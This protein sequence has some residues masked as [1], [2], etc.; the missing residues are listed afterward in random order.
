MATARVTGL[1]IYP[2]KSMRGIAL[3]H[4]SLTPLGLEHDR[5]FMVI[6]EEGR[7]VTQRDVP[8]LALIHTRLQETGIELSMQERGT[9]L[10]PFEKVDGEQ[11]LSAVWGDECQAVD[12]GGDISE[13]LTSA[14]DSTEQ[15]RLVRM[16][17]GYIR[18][19]GK[20]DELGE[21][22]HTVFADAAPY[23]VANEASLEALNCELADREFD[24]VPMDRFRPNIVLRG[25]DAFAEH[26]VSEL[27]AEG[28]RLRFCHPCQRCVV[29][30]IDQQTAVKN[31]EWQ[32]YKT[33]RDINPMPGN[34]RAPAFGHNAVLKNGEGQ[35]ISVGDTVSLSLR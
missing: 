10:V 6:R 11:V 14:L 8:R 26:R 7:F 20:P 29:T 30:T 32:P 34:E 4:A 33:L 5:R 12:T 2:V 15:L 19:Q 9:V 16:A 31:T 13:W 22:T 18:P 17:A 3:D 28:Y 24:A 35:T 23:L 27:A 25:L 21:S 1:T